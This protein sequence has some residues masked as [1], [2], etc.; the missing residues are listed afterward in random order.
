MEIAERLVSALRSAVLGQCGANDGS[1]GLLLSGGIDSRIILGS[2]EP[3]ALSSW[4][5]ASYAENPE[6]A[7]ARRVAHCCRSDFHPIINEPCRIFDWE[8]TA[9]IENN[10]LYPASPQTPRLFRLR[11]RVRRSAVWSRPRL[12]SA[13]LLFAVKISR[14]IGLIND[15]H[16]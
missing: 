14:F 3:G 9:T 11:P 15:C 4:T 6:L 5:V 16:P 10:G 13:W 8:K 12:Y 1:T 2:A 7:I